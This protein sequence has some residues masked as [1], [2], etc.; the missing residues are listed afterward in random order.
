[1]PVNQDYFPPSLLQVQGRADADHTRTEDKN[2]GLQFR[3]PPL[4]KLNT[5]R[6]ALLLTL[7]LVIQLW[8]RKP[9]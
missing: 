9:A 4:R 3:H 2:I 7:K 8:S 1:M 5:T 6:L